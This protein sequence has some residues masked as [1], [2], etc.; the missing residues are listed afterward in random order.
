VD[1]RDLVEKAREQ[2]RLGL[3]GLVVAVIGLILVFVWPYFG[4]VALVGLVVASRGMR[5]EPNTLAIGGMG[6]GGLGV[7]L[8]LV[9]NFVGSGGDASSGSRTPEMDQADL[10]VAKLEE[11]KVSVGT[12]AF[13]NGSL[14]ANLTDLGQHPA[15]YNDPWGQPFTLKQTGKK[16]FQLSSIGPDGQA[17]TED[18]VV[19]EGGF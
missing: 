3:I 14:P 17:G 5:D 16:L 19:V 4:A 6:V 1:L 12:Y 9:F 18:D 15:M 13:E 8:M 7:V 10:V 11:L 2:S